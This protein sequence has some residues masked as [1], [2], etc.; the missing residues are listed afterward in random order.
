MIYVGMAY[1]YVCVAYAR[2]LYKSI[3]LLFACVHVRLGKFNHYV[4][5]QRS[6]VNIQCLLLLLSS[7]FEVGEPVSELSGPTCLHFPS[8]G[9]SNICSPTYGFFLGRSWESDLRSSC[10]HEELFYLLSSLACLP[11]ICIL[12]T[13]GSQEGKTK[14]MQVPCLKERVCHYL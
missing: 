7:W 12:W 4:C 5:I 2:V 1:S 8:S 3:C 6:E 13:N 14:R 11:L 9:E 10:L